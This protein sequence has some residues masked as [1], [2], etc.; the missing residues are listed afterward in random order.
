MSAT[1]PRVGFYLP[2][3]DGSE[4][5]NVATDLNDNLEKIDATIGFVPALEATPPSNTFN[6]M[7]RY[8]TDSGKVSFLKAAT[9]TQI[10]AEGAT[11]LSNILMGA[12]NRIGIGT[13]TPAA[14]VDVA[15]TN[16][17]TVP[18][19]RYKA[20]GEAYPRVQVDNNGIRL[21]GGSLTPETRIYRPAPDQLSITGG[22][23]VETNLNVAGY[24]GVNSMD[25]SGNLG[26][27]GVI[28]TDLH[29]NGDFSA[30]GTGYIATI[31][32]LVDTTRTSTTTLAND[33]EL[34]VNLDANSVYMIETY[35]II[36]GSNAGDFQYSWTG[37]TGSSGLRWSLGPSAASTNRE[38]TTMR[39]G[40]HQ[41]TTAVIVG[42]HSDASFS[43]AQDTMVIT[44]T[45]AGQLIL[46]YAQG[47]SSAT[48]TTLRAGSLMQIRK[49]A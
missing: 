22:V 10:L 6:G 35:L 21:G 31:R 3:D 38:D 36:S 43:G 33:P 17:A 14:I 11:F 16:T 5:V 7:G 2:E 24:L 9:W 45:T 47:T 26:I 13:T 42:V 37:P 44:T 49:V 19:L 27:G 34:F 46:K 23:N 32:K 8:N 18:L 48:A 39:S 29:V 12:A 41:L 1:T 15:V 40:I 4:P 28:Y 30:G 25:I 20:S